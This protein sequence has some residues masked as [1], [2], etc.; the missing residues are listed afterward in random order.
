MRRNFGK[1]WLECSYPIELTN[2]QLKRLAYVGIE[3]EQTT[4]QL[5]VLLTKLTIDLETIIELASIIYI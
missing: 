1:R 2:S 3:N 4:T 5:M